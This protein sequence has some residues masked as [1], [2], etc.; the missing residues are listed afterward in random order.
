MVLSYR[1][2]TFARATRV[3]RRTPARTDKKRLRRIKRQGLPVSL[4]HTA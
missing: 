4:N 2:S 1:R 3:A